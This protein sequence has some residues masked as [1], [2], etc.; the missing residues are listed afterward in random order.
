[1]D[2][3]KQNS[4]NHQVDV[5][6][7][8]H[9]LGVK[10]REREYYLY[11]DGRG[12]SAKIKKDWVY[13]PNTSQ[14]EVLLIYA[15]CYN[16][17]QWITCPNLL[18][19]FV[20]VSFTKDEMEE[21]R[22]GKKDTK[23]HQQVNSILYSLPSLNKAFIRTESGSPKDTLHINRSSG[24]QMAPTSKSDEILYSVAT[25]SRCMEYIRAGIDKKLYIAPWV[26]LSEYSHFRVFIREE[27]VRAISQYDL[28]DPLKD[29]EKLRK[30]ILDLWDNVKD[31]LWYED[32]AMDVVYR[33]EDS[34]IK[35]VEFN[36][37]GCSSRCGS[38]LYNWITDVVELYL[39]DADVRVNKS[40][41]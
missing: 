30:T 33:E 36:E 19:K 16:V 15:S 27:K 1:M 8:P 12:L 2:L 21:I 9:K 20:F 29:V 23:L 14:D 18:N 22:Y 38:A 39:G 37:Y 32:C 26:D 28:I 25:S 17:D 5:W 7:Y 11:L 4:S 31:T 13:L 40:Y 41:I 34:D 3:Y 10:V 35:I 24:E 6:C